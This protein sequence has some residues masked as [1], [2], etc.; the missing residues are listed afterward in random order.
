MSQDEFST[1]YNQMH[2][3]IMHQYLSSDLADLTRELKIPQ[4]QI[5]SIFP[6]EGAGSQELFFTEYL[7]NLSHSPFTDISS[8]HEVSNFHT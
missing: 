5:L 7:T 8:Y 4:K 2:M 1:F 6:G 3:R